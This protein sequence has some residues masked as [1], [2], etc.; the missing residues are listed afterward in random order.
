M[1]VSIYSAVPYSDAMFK[2]KEIA[3]LLAK[4]E[5][6][7][8]VLPIK[9]KIQPGAAPGQHTYSKG[10]IE[11]KEKKEKKAK[12]NLRKPKKQRQ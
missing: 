4:L 3:R 7:D 8:E 1:T 11:K 2:P 10:I 12:K 5:K 6:G 9:R